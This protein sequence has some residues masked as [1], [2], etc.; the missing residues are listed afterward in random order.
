MLFRSTVQGIATVP[1]FIWELFLGL[2][3]TFKGFKSAAITS[4]YP[5]P[6]GVDAPFAA[7]AAAAV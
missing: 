7:P 3:L 4:S 1:E 6:V 5:R 2:W